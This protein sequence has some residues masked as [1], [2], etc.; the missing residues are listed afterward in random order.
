MLE[1]YRILIDHII[2]SEFK[3]FLV[4]IIFSYQDHDC[5]LHIPLC[6]REWVIGIPDKY[7]TAGTRASKLMDLGSVELEVGK[8]C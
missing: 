2:K 1:N 7:I 8:K 3:V 5:N 6:K 4:M